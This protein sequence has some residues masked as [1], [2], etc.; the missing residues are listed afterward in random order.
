[1]N[2]D[3][4]KIS[5]V[6]VADI[7]MKDYPDFCDAYIEECEIDGRLATDEEL[8]VINDNSDFVYEAVMDYVF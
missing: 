3:F 5:N 2:I 4:S 8:D 1:M 7:D 6:S